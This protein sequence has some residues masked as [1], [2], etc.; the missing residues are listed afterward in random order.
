MLSVWETTSCGCGWTRDGDGARCSLALSGVDLMFDPAVTQYAAEV[1]NGVAE[2][3]AAPDGLPDPP[4]NFTGEVM[5]I[6]K[7]PVKLDW[8]DV[9]GATGYG[10]QFYT[11]TPDGWVELPTADIDIVFDGSNAT[12][13]G[14][15]DYDSFRARAGRSNWSPGFLTLKNPYH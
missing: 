15:P 2:T 14:L 3:T 7:G 13:S 11:P 5:V 4:E 8:D 1:T 9:A 12:I 6:G 10:I